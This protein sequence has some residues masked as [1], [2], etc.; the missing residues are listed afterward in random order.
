MP[1][2]RDN[3]CIV[4]NCKS[5]YDSTK[6]EKYHRFS[7]PFEENALLEWKKAIPR[8]DF[9]LKSGMIVCDKHFLSDDIVWRREV[10][11]PATG[12]VMASV[13]IFQ[14]L[15]IVSIIYDCY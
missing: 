4:P 9:D 15:L 11:D 13:R 8:K 7:V 5:G 2:Y 12:N 1:R 3:R 14:I 10:K 6:G